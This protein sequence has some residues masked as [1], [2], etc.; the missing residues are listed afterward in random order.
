M[1]DSGKNALLMAIDVGNTDTVIGLFDGVEL[2][3]HWRV[4][5]E[6]ERRA[7]EYGMLMW[8][9]FHSAGMDVPRVS[10]VV[11]ACVVP[12]MTAVIERVCH[13]YF[14][15]EPLIVGPGI[16]TGMPILYENPREVGADRICNAVAAL[17][18][19]GRAT[20][21]VDFGTATTFDYITEKGEYLGGVIAPG[22]GI[23]LDALYTRTAKLPRVELVR[24]ERVVGRN[25]TGAIQAGVFYGYV[26]LV[27]GIVGHIRRDE[28]VEASVIATGG[29]ASLIAPE[30]K[31]I[32]D[33]DEFLTLK[34]LRMVH[35]HNR[36]Q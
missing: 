35:A 21:I 31:T 18:R 8:S 27:D 1:S 19:T 24:P 25:T 36:S 3:H 7:D 10:D 17:E 29:L 4:Q 14:K 6:S 26:E 5:T 15:A 12:P 20:I 33:V 23:S 34:G 28:G 30:S 16:K 32:E 2:V 13:D 9:L 11:V 22:I